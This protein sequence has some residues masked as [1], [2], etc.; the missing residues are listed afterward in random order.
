MDRE[1]FHSTEFTPIIVEPF[2]FTF[3]T[4]IHEFDSQY[5]V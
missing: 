5:R 1:P 4:V 3:Q 2:V